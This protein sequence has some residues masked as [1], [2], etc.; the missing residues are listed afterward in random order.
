MNKV[1]INKNDQLAAELN[2]LA[3]EHAK[4][5]LCALLDE[6]KN[7]NGT[8]HVQAAEIILERGLGKPAQQVTLEGEL[9]IDPI[10]PDEVLNILD[11]IYMS[12][13]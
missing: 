11:G 1:L 3:R 10:L 9:E 8:S 5:A 13:S 12:M 2:T 4:D 7:G 6:L